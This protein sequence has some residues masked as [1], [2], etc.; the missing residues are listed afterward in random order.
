MQEREGRLQKDEREGLDFIKDER[1]ERIS[2]IIKKGK[3]YGS[4][5]L[6]WGQK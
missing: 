4:K 5:G 6:G 1:E 2:A 3:K